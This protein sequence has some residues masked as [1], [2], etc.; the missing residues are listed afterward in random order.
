MAPCSIME[1]PCFTAQKD[2]ITDHIM[3]FH[4]GKLPLRHAAKMR[5]KLQQAHER[6]PDEPSCTYRRAW[7]RQRLVTCM[8]SMGYCTSG[9]MTPLCSRAQAR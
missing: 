5:A 6:M 8:M 1:S 3:H 4:S 7:R 2:Q 9:R